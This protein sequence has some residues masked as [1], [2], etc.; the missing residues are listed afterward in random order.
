VDIQIAFST[1]L[2]IPAGMSVGLFVEIRSTTTT[3]VELLLFADGAPQARPCKLALVGSS[4]ITAG[5]PG[6]RLTLLPQLDRYVITDW[7]SATKQVTVQLREPGKKLVLEAT[8]RMV[9]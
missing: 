6:A 3:T 4:N 7:G 9:G 2:W 8:T 5:A 1:T